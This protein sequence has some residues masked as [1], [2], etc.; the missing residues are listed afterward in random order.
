MA[1]TFNQE[2]QN[3]AQSGYVEL[4]DIDTT[5]IGG[6]S[7][8]HFVHDNYTSTEILWRGNYYSPFPL[9]ATG[10]EWSGNTS[11]PPKPTFVV[12]NVNQ[13]L[14]AAVLSL[15]DLVGAKVTRWR[16]FQRFLDGQSDA[17]PNGHLPTDV[18]L[19]DQKVTH[20]KSTIQFSLISPMDR[21][22]LMLPRRQ[23]LKDPTANGV[24]F[25]GVARTRF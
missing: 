1:V 21:Q 20:N 23:I 13:F 3:F 10:F 2:L 11:A 18:Y 24:F 15:G 12:S 7:V 8:Y 14:L 6:A 19:I 16:T 22:G 9:E 5:V 25:P 4:F 17:D